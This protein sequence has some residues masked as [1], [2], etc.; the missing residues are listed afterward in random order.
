[1]AMV[2]LCAC[3]NIVSAKDTSESGESNTESDIKQDWKQFGKD[4]A[5][6][7]RALGKALGTTGK[8]IGRNV[9][10][11][12]NID[13]NG[14]W[15]YT[16]KKTSTAIVINKDGTME[17]TQKSGLDVSYWKGTV[18][19]T[20]SIILFRISVSG[21]KT[22]FSA[23]EVKNNKTWHLLYTIDKDKGAMSVTC[24]DIPTDASGHNFSNSTV[25]V[26][27]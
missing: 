17:I 22:G 26:K 23:D 9:K 11:S 27:R 19:G 24:S 6:T 2:C 15:V 21:H 3:M 12:L 4:S 20:L 13:Y 14:T 5:A 7:A 16:G 10:N 8:K 18:S 1:M 25:F